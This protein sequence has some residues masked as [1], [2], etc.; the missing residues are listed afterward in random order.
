MAAV[1]REAS[2]VERDLATVDVIC[3]YERSIDFVSDTIRTVSICLPDKLSKHITSL[4]YHSCSA[5][6]RELSREHGSYIFLM[7]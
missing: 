4:T 1:L 6:I 7:C 3:R 5:F 2:V